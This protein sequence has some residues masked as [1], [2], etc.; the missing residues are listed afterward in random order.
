MKT[1]AVLLTAGLLL[2]GSAAARAAESETAPMPKNAPQTA[3]G[4]D[5]PAPAVQPVTGVVSD[6]AAPAGGDCSCRGGHLRRIWDWL[7]W[8]PMVCRSKDC[9]C[10]GC[11]CCCPPVYTFFFCNCGYPR[12]RLPFPPYI[13]QGQPPRDRCADGHCGGGCCH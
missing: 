7:T 4:T 9:C 10:K 8:R 6:C 3:P 5:A 11:A 1:T 12:A 2:A 13:G